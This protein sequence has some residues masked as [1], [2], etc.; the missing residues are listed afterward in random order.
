MKKNIITILI[1]ITVIVVPIG[2][3]AKENSFNYRF[4]E[5]A[6]KNNKKSNQGTDTSQWNEGYNQEQGCSGDNSILGNV[7]DPNSVAW[8]LQKVLD[9]L[10]V[11]GPILVVVL[12]SVEFAK[13]IIKSD[14]EAMVKA[15][16]M[17]ITRLIL[18]ASLFLI[19][20]LVEAVLS[21][22]NFTSDTL[23]GIK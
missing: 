2:V 12:S 19:P 21:W 13:V 5:I 20:Q 3:N 15:Q 10:K 7:N 1:L 22:F 17:L 16:K 14:D 6:E 9:F 23:C 18:A 11:L 8:L 4:I